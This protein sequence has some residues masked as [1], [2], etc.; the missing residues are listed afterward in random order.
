VR[1]Y[2]ITQKTAHAFAVFLC[3]YF[4]LLLRYSVFWIFIDVAA[5]KRKS[6]RG[7]FPSPEWLVGISTTRLLPLAL[8][9]FDQPITPLA[10]GRSGRAFFL[11]VERTLVRLAYFTHRLSTA[12]AGYQGLYRLARINNLFRRVSRLKKSLKMQYVCYPWIP[13]LGKD[14]GADP[15]RMSSELVFC[16]F[17]QISLDVE[18]D[19]E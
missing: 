1:K 11:F 9:P 10:S 3:S 13:I 17:L 15:S 8:R 16:Q 2:D 19:G 14:R 7:W 5:L 6:G 4:F 18:L 12:Q